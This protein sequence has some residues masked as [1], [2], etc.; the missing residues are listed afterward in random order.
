MKTQEDASKCD[1]PQEQQQ[2]QQRGVNLGILTNSHPAQIS[3][4]QVQEAG[5][6]QTCTASAGPSGKRCQARA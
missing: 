2:Q 5:V 6:R 1:R 3:A 4:G